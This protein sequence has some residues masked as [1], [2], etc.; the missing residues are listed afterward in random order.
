MHPN[1]NDTLLKGD[2]MYIELKTDRLRL[3]PLIAADLDAVH[4]YAGDPD[5]ARYMMFLPKESKAETARFLTEVSAE[6]EKESQSF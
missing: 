2:A 6:W 3:C 5:N 4:A 1:E